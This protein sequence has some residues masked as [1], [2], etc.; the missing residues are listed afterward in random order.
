ML[1]TLPQRFLSSVSLKMVGLARNQKR[2]I[3]M[4]FD[5]ALCIVAT[6]IAFSLRMG[7]WLP[8]N[9]GVLLA[10]GFAVVIA[11][12][13]FIVFGLYRAIFRHSGWSALN[14]IVMACGVFGVLYACIFALV[15]IPGVPRTVGLIQP[16]ITFLGVAG[17]RAVV[18]LLLNY[19]FVDSPAALQR[20]RVGIYGAGN[21]GVQLFAALAA[22]KDFDVVAFFDDDESLHGSVLRGRPIYH[23]E[24]IEA[25]AEKLDFDDVL[26]ALPSA[27]QRRRNEIAALVRGG[28][29]SVRILPAVADIAMGRISV[30]D[31]RTI[32]ID[33][34]L[35]RAMVKPNRFLMLAGVENKRV[36]VTGAGGSIGSELCRQIVRLGPSSLIL[37]DS[38]EYAL[39]A[40]QRELELILAAEGLP[41]Q[42]YAVLGSV[43]DRG[44]VARILDRWRPQTLFH[45]A[46]YK[47]VPLVELN[48]AAG[49]VNNIVGTRVVA[50]EAVEAGVERFVLIS[51]DK[52]VRPTNVMGATKRVAELI[53]QA[54][55]S[56]GSP[57][58]FT[59]VRFGNVLESSGSVVPL[60]RQQIKNGGPVTIT[61][62]EITRFFMTIPEAA[63]LVIQAGAMA[64]G[65]EVFLLHM[66]EP[67]RIL[68]LARNMIE[69]SGLTVQSEENPTGDVEVVFTGL[70]PG[71]KLFEEL[72]VDDNALSTDHPR[73]MVAAES[74]WPADDL[75]AIIDDLTELATRHDA[76]GIRR[77][78]GRL[79]EEFPVEGEL[80][81]NF[82]T[83]FVGESDRLN[84][85]PN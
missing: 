24:H 52:A 32:E 60:F 11:I 79:V 70:R 47:H 12:P 31:L 84:E 10:M 16:I 63:Q 13:N 38:S 33:D 44:H 85:L 7:E 37:V 21:A 48:V 9:P 40:I 28:R 56:E 6:Q 80:Y 2:L 3:A 49:V 15:G 68:D 83:S 35:G 51:S 75:R 29:V 30:N 73:I 72:L 59:M 27:S 50:E 36:L 45:A 67:V 22:S 69:L 57:T 17:S 41:V 34:L 39:Y 18:R 54:L 46:A 77:Q 58:C 76:A 20:K 19:A 23:P 8:F 14:S 81:D 53:L 82:L 42:L 4:V 5:V 1:A 43:T 74:F 78:L 26:L 64:K 25:I 62:P 65:G 71:E 61:H 66:G 55:A